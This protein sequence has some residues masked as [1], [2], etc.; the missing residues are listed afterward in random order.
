MVDIDYIKEFQG[1]KE[2]AKPPATRRSAYD[3][4]SGEDKRARYNLDYFMDG[5]KERRN[6]KERRQIGERRSGWA[7]VYKWCSV[8]LGKKVS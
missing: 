2:S 1:Q 4:R 8:F 3:R 6:G 5:G 7:R